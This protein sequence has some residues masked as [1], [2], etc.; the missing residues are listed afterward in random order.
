MDRAAIESIFETNEKLIRR[1]ALK[2]GAKALTIGTESLAETIDEI[3]D[4]YAL[5]G[6]QRREL[7]PAMAIE[8]Q[9]VVGK[10][11]G[12]VGP[13]AIL[14]DL[15]GGSGL[16]SQ[17]RAAGRLAKTARVIGQGGLK[18]GRIAARGGRAT[19]ALPW[20]ALGVAAWSVGNG[21]WFW[22]RAHAYN[23]ACRDLL[24]QEVGPK[25]VPAA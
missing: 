25:T 17:A 18:A 20:A 19:R 22:W 3:A 9:E 10:L 2:A 15:R 6:A 11:K 13:V 7:E 24:L 12:F 1:R 5:N 8:A 16:L 23:R 21:G 4:A 14:G